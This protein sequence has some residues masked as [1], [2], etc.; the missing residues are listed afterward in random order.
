MGKLK[1]HYAE[2]S[3]HPNESDNTEEWTETVCGFEPEDREHL[4]YNIMDITC[5]NCLNKLSKG[6]HE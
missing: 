2:I 4:S 6:H 3:H 1:I 5:K